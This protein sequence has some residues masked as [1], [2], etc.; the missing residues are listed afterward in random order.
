MADNDAVLIKVAN[1]KV[2][3]LKP[4]MIIGRQADC[5]LQLVEGHASRRHSR[6]TVSGNDV[7]IEDLGSSNGTFIN[8]VRIAERVK[9]VSGDR[10]RFD[11]EEFD[12]RGGARPAAD[13]G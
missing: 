5:E 2:V 1:G 7:W 10:V 4:E 11:I 13:D 3:A 6:I 8:G 9:L 12:F